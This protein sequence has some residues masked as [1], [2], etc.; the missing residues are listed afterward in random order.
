MHLRILINLVNWHA[1]HA[2]CTSTYTHI[3]PTPN[4]TCTLTLTHTH[5]C[6]CTRT[7]V[8]TLIHPHSHSHPPTCTHAL[9][10]THTRT[11]THMRKR[12][13]ITYTYIHAYRQTE[14]RNKSKEEAEDPPIK[15]SALHKGLRTTK[16]MG[17]HT[18]STSS[19]Q[20]MH[21]SQPFIRRN[22]ATGSARPS[23]RGIKPCLHRRQSFPQHVRSLSKKAHH[24]LL[25]TCA[26]SSA[27]RG[28]ASQAA[29]HHPS[30][31]PHHT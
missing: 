31:Q 23:L 14:N 15:D 8:L 21:L 18:S 25:R 5:T 7:N 12:A 28:P 9:A 3:Q 26:N 30:A 27:N 11:H 16:Q 19:T 13:L 10:R 6:I 4:H 22:D 1:R 20:S 29:S 2:Q 24:Y 17:A